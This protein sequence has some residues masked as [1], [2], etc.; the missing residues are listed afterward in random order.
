MQKSSPAHRDQAGELLQ[1][2]WAERARKTC[3]GEGRLFQRGG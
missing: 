3:P 2:T 1:E